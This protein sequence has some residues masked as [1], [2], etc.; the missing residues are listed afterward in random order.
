MRLGVQLIGN[1]LAAS[2]PG[3]ALARHGWVDNVVGFPVVGEHPSAER[4][5]DAL[6]RR[7]IDAAL[8]WGPQVGWFARRSPA[9]LRVS[10]LQPPADLPHELGFEF[11]M[12]MGVRRADRDLKQALEDFI[13]RRQPDIDRILAE[14]AVP[15]VDRP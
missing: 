8:V 13:R 3:Y 2:P 14:Y 12:A 9:P 7:E 5:V 4:M 15:R 10:V 1:D 6:A 11:A